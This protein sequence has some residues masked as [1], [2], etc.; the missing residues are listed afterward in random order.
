MTTDR[1]SWR[2]GT[3]AQWTLTNPVLAAGEPGYE[4]DTR[5][6]KVGDGRHPWADLTYIQMDSRIYTSNIAFGPTPPSSP[7]RGS[8]WIRSEAGTF[9]A[10]PLPPV[11]LA[12]RSASSLSGSGSLV[13]VSS[14]RPSGTVALSSLGTLTGT[15]TAR[16]PTSGGGGGG[17]GT[18][19]SYPYTVFN[20]SWEDR[21]F[22]G[23]D[24]VGF[25]T[26]PGSYSVGSC[27]LS[28]GLYQVSA[29]FYC[30]SSQPYP[31]QRY[32]EGYVE[33]YFTMSNGAASF[34]RRTATTLGS[35]YSYTTS[36]FRASGTVSFNIVVTDSWYS[37]PGG[38]PMITVT[39][40]GA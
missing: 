6:V 16:I 9:Q 2:R 23:G 21:P 5:R 7:A 25:W 36:T 27:F 15:G 13:A 32:N 11:P 38:R 18:T 26:Q 24:S 30:D 12:F 4:T 35:S 19:T 29:Y 20:G 37:G 31:S 28:Y 22:N 1:V 33:G 10:V 34:P 3:R 17:G 40:V 8:I 39:A 14:Y